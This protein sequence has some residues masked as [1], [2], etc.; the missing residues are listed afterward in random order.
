MT[1]ILSPWARQGHI[2][3]PEKQKNERNAA[4]FHVATSLEIVEKSSLHS[5][6]E[7][8]VLLQARCGAIRNDLFSPTLFMEPSNGCIDPKFKVYANS[9]PIRTVMWVPLPASP[10]RAPGCKKATTHRQYDSASTRHKLTLSWP[11][12]RMYFFCRARLDISRLP[13]GKRRIYLN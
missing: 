6:G 1:S 5:P 2:E 3:P 10:H 4:D 13:G 11:F 12:C 9:G 7:I 8:A